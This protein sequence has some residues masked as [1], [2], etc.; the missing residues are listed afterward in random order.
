M[1]VQVERLGWAGLGGGGGGGGGSWKC[2]WQ[3]N[4]VIFL[5]CNCLF[6]NL[7]EIKI[8]L[9][10]IFRKI[11]F[12]MFC[13]PLS[14]P[15]PPHLHVSHLTAS[16]SLT[17]LSL[18]VISLLFYHTHQPVSMKETVVLT[19]AQ[20]DQ[21]LEVRSLYIGCMGILTWQLIRHQN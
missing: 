6:L 9:F 13:I 21:V 11:F 19:A 12:T 1:F 7:S 10:K 18:S 15:T 16:F 14:P 17:F 4:Y 3:N 2:V 8:P 5:F 20:E